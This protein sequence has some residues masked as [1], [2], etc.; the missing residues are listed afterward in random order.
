MI[1]QPKCYRC[2]KPINFRLSY[3]KTK[4]NKYTCNDCTFLENEIN[5]KLGI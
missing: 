5:K 4:L 1:N 2:K 3:R